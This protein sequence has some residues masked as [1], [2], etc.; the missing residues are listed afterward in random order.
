[1][2]LHKSNNTIK[3]RLKS[4][5][6]NGQ[7]VQRKRYWP[8]GRPGW[9]ARVCMCSWPSAVWDSKTSSHLKFFYW[10]IKKYYQSTADMA[11]CRPMPARPPRS[12]RAIKFAQVKHP[13][14][15]TGT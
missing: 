14:P 15:L 10:G 8:P 7:A 13:Y 11:V 3:S 12:A 6:T 2:L 9:A 4:L 1:M 5:I